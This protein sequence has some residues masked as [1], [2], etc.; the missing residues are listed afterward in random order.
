MEAMAA[1]MASIGAPRAAPYTVQNKRNLCVVK[2]G[3]K[4]T[5]TK[6]WRAGTGSSPGSF[7]P[8][9]GVLYRVSVFPGSP[10]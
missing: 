4:I 10:R 8:E 7:L 3:V 2:A 1:R 6:T 9:T 5:T